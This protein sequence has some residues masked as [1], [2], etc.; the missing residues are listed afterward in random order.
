MKQKKQD[1]ICSFDIN[2]K[3]K[4]NNIL[5]SLSHQPY[6]PDTASEN[7]VQIKRRQIPFDI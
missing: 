4:I 1:N 7:R 6:Y 3:I 2:L 5:T